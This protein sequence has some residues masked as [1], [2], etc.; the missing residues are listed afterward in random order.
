MIALVVGVVLAVAALVYVLLPLFDLRSGGV[1]TRVPARP[2]AAPEGA[3]DALREIEFDRATGKLSDD[4]YA[5]LKAEYTRT[6]LVELRA[7]DG[8]TA[9]GVVRTPADPVA[10]SADVAG[11][12]DA[13]EAA[14]MKYRTLRRSCDTCGPRPEPD[15][16]FCS[17]CG[18]YLRGK[19]SH[20]GATV[21]APASRFCSNCGNS[22][23]A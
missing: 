10:A 13:A 4:D 12:V 20:C 3:I 19:C 11:V 16:A 5:A 17:S 6:A 2:A 1:P 9:E 22:L 23:A 21:D 7:R 14:V 18:K 15:P 8:A